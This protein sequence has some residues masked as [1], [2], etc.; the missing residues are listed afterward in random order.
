MITA[1]ALTDEQIHEYLDWL[2]N[3]PY[4]GKDQRTMI[5]EGIHACDVALCTV[6]IDDIG[7]VQ[8][9]ACRRGDQ[10]QG[11]RVPLPRPR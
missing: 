8:E 6:R 11:C 3:Q 10:R 7:R 9:G 1:S 4:L 2:T 5:R